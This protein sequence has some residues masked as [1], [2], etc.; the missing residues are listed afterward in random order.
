MHVGIANPW[1]RGKRSRHSRCMRN[2]QFYISGNKPM[3][4][5]LW[6]G[7]SS[8]NSDP[9]LKICKTVK[10]NFSR[11]WITM[12]NCLWNG[13]QPSDNLTL[14][15]PHRNR[16]NAKIHWPATASL[17]KIQLN[18]SYIRGFELYNH[19]T[20]SNNTRTLAVWNTERPPLIQW[21]HQVKTG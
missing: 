2:P 9:F 15:N 4:A 7:E 3:T 1:C 13:T 14:W 12:K 11:I 6:C 8:F 20:R 17:Q 21:R 18:S 5:Q 10:R 16:T 19:T